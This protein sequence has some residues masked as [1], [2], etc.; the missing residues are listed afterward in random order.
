M[1]FFE[2]RRHVEGDDLGVTARDRVSSLIL[3]GLVLVGT[4]VLV[5]F[6]LLVLPQQPDDVVMTYRPE[7]VDY[8]E[9]PTYVPQD[10]ETPDPSELPGVPLLQTPALFAAS[11]EQA[12]EEV[13][14]LDAAIVCELT[15]DLE[16][17]SGDPIKMEEISRC[18]RWKIE[19]TTAGID[20][21]ARQLDYFEIELGVAGDG[22]KNVDYASGFANS[23][24]NSRTAPGHDERLRI[25]SHAVSISKMDKQFLRQAGIIVKD[26]VVLHF[27]SR[28]LES[29]LSELEKSHADGRKTEEIL[30]TLYGTQ[31]TEDGYAFVVKKQ[32]YRWPRDEGSLPGSE[33]GSHLNSK[34]AR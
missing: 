10:F 18:E 4:I 33:T 30:Y 20:A 8:E 29:T 5:L 3:A 2:S 24:P 15:V 25:A 17:E 9:H 11:V 28:E 7:L 1:A 31:Q 19:Y 12:M 14:Q 27:Y 21:Y 16:S 32:A 26:R 13:R 34:K 23:R 22:K 6:G